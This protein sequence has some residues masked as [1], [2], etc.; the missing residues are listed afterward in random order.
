MNGKV[1][2][3]VQECKL[4]WWQAASRGLPGYLTVAASNCDSSGN[5]WLWVWAI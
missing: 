4:R 1:V 3:A 2:P 5:H